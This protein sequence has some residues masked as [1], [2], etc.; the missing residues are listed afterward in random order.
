MQVL[1]QARVLKEAAHYIFK[2]NRTAYAYIR[3]HS[4]TYHS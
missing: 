2:E 4:V 1:G 3:R